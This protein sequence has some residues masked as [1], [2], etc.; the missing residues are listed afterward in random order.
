LRAALASTLTEFAL[1][2][3]FDAVICMGSAI[4]YVKTVDRLRF[5]VATMARHCVA[6]GVT[7]VEPFVSNDRGLNSREEAYSRRRD[8]HGGRGSLTP[9]ENEKPSKVVM[10]RS[11]G[12]SRVMGDRGFEPRT[13][14]LSERRS[15]QL[16]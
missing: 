15:N 8:R 10:P 1:G 7:I 6:R 4:G 3:T 12:L 9:L 16:S 14:A 11:G 2:R 13:S 5:A